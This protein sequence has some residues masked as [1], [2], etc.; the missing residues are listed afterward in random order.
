MSGA[1]ITAIL[2]LI[3][4][5]FIPVLLICIRHQV[6]V[7]RIRLIEIHE[8]NYGLDGVKAFEV[9]KDRY[10]IDIPSY[11]E[12]INHEYISDRIR[13]TFFY[14]SSWVLLVSALPYSILVFIGYF[15]ILTPSTTLY[16][17]FTSLNLSGN[18][19]FL[20]QI[21]AYSSDKLRLAP[22]VLMTAFLGAFFFTIRYM[23]RAVMVFDLSSI[24]FIRAFSHILLTTT[25]AALLWRSIYSGDY[26]EATAAGVIVIAFVVGFLPDAGVYFVS[27]MINVKMK[28][29][30]TDVENF[31]PI[32]PLTIVDG[33]DAS[34]EYRL[35]E[36]GICD[37]QNL[38]VSNPVMLCV[39]TPYPLFEIL[40]WTSQSQL[41]TALGPEK[42]LLLRERGIRTVFDL[43]RAVL[44]KGACDALIF[45]IASVLFAS[46]SSEAAIKSKFKIQELSESSYFASYSNNIQRND[47]VEFV[48]ILTDDL[49]IHRVRQIW[50]A[51]T[52]KMGIRPEDIASVSYVNQPS[53]RDGM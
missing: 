47:V 37:V 20:Y 3:F 22:I 48:K 32:L 21:Q 26:A 41:C 49:H 12:T 44:S 6:R 10:L 35:E 31:S 29:R 18:S 4:S 1:I 42:F 13:Y 23:I 28:R 16:D 40:D 36:A 46:T 17:I 7:N 51:A 39:E 30:N 53:P 33:I 52:K 45:R 34:T 14:F 38:A 27:S 25:V 19:I 43:E 2:S 9:V 15:F 24:T 50:I 5:L 8:K 11:R